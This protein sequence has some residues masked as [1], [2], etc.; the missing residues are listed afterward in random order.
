MRFSIR[1]TSVIRFIRSPVTA[2][3]AGFFLSVCPQA[4]LSS[5]E[6]ILPDSWVYPALRSFQLAGYVDLGPTTPYSRREVELY[7]ERILSAVEADGRILTRRKQFLL[8]RL[9]AEFVSMADLPAE[10][11]DSPLLLYQE[12][13]NYIALDVPAG[14]LAG[15]QIGGNDGE[16]WGLARPEL[17]L[18]LGERVTA[19]VVYSWRLGPERETNISGG[20]PSPRERSWRGLVSEFEK[21]VISISGDSW[22]FSAGRDYL[23]WGSG[24]EEGLLLSKTAHSIDHVAAM[25]SIG[26]LSFHAVHALLDPEFPRRFSGHRLTI[27]LPRGI[28][29]GVGET[30]VYTG[31]DVEFSYLL[32]FSIFYAN[33]YNE[34]EDDNILWGL[35]L[36]V[37]V[38]RGLIL[39]GELLIDDFQ[40]ESDPPAPNRLGFNFTAEA[41][42]TV[43]GREIEL[44]AGYTFID[45]YTY[46]HKDSLFT[47]YVTGSGDPS[48]DFLI[49][50]PLGPDADRW[51][52][53]IS[54]PLHYRLEAVFEAAFVRKG[55]GNDLREWDRISDPGPAFPSGEVERETLLSLFGTF[56]FGAGSYVRAGGGWRHV[57]EGAQDLDEKDWFLYLEAILDF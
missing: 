52:A 26:R 17:L 24:R 29:L 37:P 3:A 34:A 2:L 38:T 12:R 54:T 43:G 23:H 18:G 36:K 42:V 46:A 33:Q 39:Y 40:Y 25:L 53:R 5:D 49:G 13:E 6:T 14:I 50:S 4:A 31:R 45:I 48:I 19:A 51:N 55:E 9:E 15:K 1:H 28:F 21:S 44:L 8:E 7:V 10:R 32:P 47:R 35:D 56:D 16:V 57:K 11:E 20:K 41:M 30:V 22:R 27:R